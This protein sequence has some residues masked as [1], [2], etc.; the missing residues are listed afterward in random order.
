[1]SCMNGLR[2]ADCSK[3]QNGSM[4]HPLEVSNGV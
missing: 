1:M 3:A 4:V 2:I